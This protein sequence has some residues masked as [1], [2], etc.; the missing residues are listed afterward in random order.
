MQKAALIRRRAFTLLEVMVCIAV[1]GLIFIIIGPSIAPAGRVMQRADVDTRTQQIAVVALEKLFHEI[2]Y[3]NGRGVT[4]QQ[5]PQLILSYPSTLEPSYTGQPALAASDYT[6]TG[7]FSTPI[8]WKKFSLVSYDSAAQTIVRKDL[9]F[10]GGQ[11]L[12][13]IQPGRLAVLNTSP[14]YRSVKLA[15]SVKKFSVEQLTQNV[16]KV[17]VTVTQAWDSDRTTHLQTE[18][19]MRNR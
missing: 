5:T 6:S 2:A 16:I 18:I 14:L 9:P 1:L 19:S 3:S 7:V 12:V 13:H 11:E 10:A 8:T 4:L 15:T 17:E